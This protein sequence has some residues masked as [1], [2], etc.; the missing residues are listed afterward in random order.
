MAFL[1]VSDLMTDP[2]FTD[3]VALITRASS[4][5]QYGENVMIET[6]KNIIAVVQTGGKELLEFVPEGARLQD[7]ISVH[8]KGELSAERPGG[9]SDIIVY[10]SKRY[11]VQTV[12]ENYMNYG[13]GYCHAICQLEP[14]SV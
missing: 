1:D 3:V 9:Y 5:N 8:Y 14:V 12:V 11:Q 13:H 4:I 2:D 6:T 7:F 10:N